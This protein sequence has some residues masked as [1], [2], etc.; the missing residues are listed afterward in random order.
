MYDIF[1]MSANFFSC[2]DIIAGTVFVRKIKDIHDWCNYTILSA[3]PTL[4]RLKSTMQ[5]ENVVTQEMCPNVK[6]FKHCHN[7]RLKITR[8]VGQ[9]YPEQTHSI[10]SMRNNDNNSGN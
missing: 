7:F 9:V 6:C 2:T 10:G 4:F 1:I 3:Y 8:S 5:K